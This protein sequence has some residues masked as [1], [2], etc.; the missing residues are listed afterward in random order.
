MS[1]PNKKEYRKFAKGYTGILDV[2]RA[3]MWAATG[4]SNYKLRRDIFP[5]VSVNNLPE[6]DPDKKCKCKEDCDCDDD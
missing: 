1:Q 2:D 6:T 5:G 4:N 3:Y